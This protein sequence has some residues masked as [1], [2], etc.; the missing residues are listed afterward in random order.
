M[1]TENSKREMLVELGLEESLI[2]RNPDY[3]DAIIGCQLPTPK[4]V[5]L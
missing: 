1:E 5:G 2:F 3:E 4:G